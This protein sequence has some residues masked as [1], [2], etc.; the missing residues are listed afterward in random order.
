[1]SD[2]FAQTVKQQA[3]IVKII[4]DYVKLRK[5]GSWQGELEHQTKD[6]STISS[7]ACVAKRSA[8]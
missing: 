5:T 3:D 6:G 1:M 7:P 8:P 4:G 2:N